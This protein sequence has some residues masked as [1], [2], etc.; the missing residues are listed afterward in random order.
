MFC[1]FFK[2][3]CHGRSSIFAHDRNS[4]IACLAR[5]NIDWNLAKKRDAQPFRFAFATATDR[6]DDMVLT[7]LS[8]GCQAIR[9]LGTLG[10]I[11]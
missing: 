8:R 4:A 9:D 6:G 11:P 5:G 2:F 10:L 7:M 3:G 1:D